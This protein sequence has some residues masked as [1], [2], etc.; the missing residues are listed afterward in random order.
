MG[1]EELVT[2]RTGAMIV[3]MMKIEDLLVRVRM[4]GSKIEAISI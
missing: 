4:A 1:L 2:Q 3:C